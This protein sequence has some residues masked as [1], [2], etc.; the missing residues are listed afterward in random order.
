MSADFCEFCHTAT[1]LHLPGCENVATDT[2]DPYDHTKKQAA[3]WGSW[4]K[5]PE[6]MNQPPAEVPATTIQRKR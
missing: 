6:T 4:F 3:L 5:Q 2:T 1:G